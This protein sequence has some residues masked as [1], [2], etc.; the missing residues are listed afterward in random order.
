V[1]NAELG[2]NKAKILVDT[3]L[4]AISVESER[5]ANS[6]PLVSTYSSVRATGERVGNGIIQITVS[7]DRIA[8]DYN[9]NIIS[10]SSNSGVIA[11]TTEDE[12]KQ[13]G[14]GQRGIN[15][16]ANQV[17]AAANINLRVDQ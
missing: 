9:G 17:I 2:E 5:E 10:Q 12:I 3:S 1:L 11:F 16:I 4:N 7:I 14:G 6:S 15:V 13:F 8:R